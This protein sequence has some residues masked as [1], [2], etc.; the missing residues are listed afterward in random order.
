MESNLKILTLWDNKEMQTFVQPQSS[1]RLEIIKKY[2][3]KIKFWVKKC[4]KFSKEKNQIMENY[5]SLV[6][7]NPSA[8]LIILWMILQNFIQNNLIIK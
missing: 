2:K 1:Q 5:N 8:R 7:N 4:K 3:E 6:L